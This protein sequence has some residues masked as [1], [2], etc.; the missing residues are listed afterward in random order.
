MNH[1]KA[2]WLYITQPGQTLTVRGD[3]FG[4]P[5]GMPLKTD[6]NLVGYPTLNDTETVANALWGTGA[7]NVA[8]GDPAE[9]Y[10]IKDV[11]PTY[12]INPGG[13]YWVHVVEDSVWVVDW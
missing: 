9:P 6:W 13:G 12:V 2:F 3:K 4:S 8:V 7:D 11:G 1:F 5:I 10:R